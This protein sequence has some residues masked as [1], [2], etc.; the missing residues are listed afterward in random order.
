M[1]NYLNLLKTIYTKEK[2][3]EAEDI[4]TCLALINTLSKDTSNLNALEKISKYIFNCSPRILFILL[5]IHIPRKQ[6]IPKLIKIEVEKES[7]NKDKYREL[8]QE[9]KKSFSWSERE[10]N[11]NKKVLDSLDTERNKL[12]EL[13]G[14]K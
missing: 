11:L 14:V 12:K 2:L 13:Y 3:E 1:S 10:L 6:Y 7:K 4:G 8:Y 5:Y 9:I